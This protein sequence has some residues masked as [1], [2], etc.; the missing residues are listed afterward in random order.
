[1]SRC[2]GKAKKDFKEA[3]Q[4]EKAKEVPAQPVTRAD[5]IQKRRLKIEARTRRIQVRQARAAKAKET[6]EDQ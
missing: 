3:V 5:R 2:C 1:M 4:K 6:K